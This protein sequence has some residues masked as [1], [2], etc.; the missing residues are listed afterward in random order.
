MKRKFD[1]KQKILK[2]I[3]LLAVLCMVQSTTSYAQNTVTINSKM[4]KITYQSSQNVYV[5]FE[6][7]DG[8]TAGDTLYVKEKNKL[9]PVVKI[10]FISSKSCA[11]EKISTIS[12]NDKNIIFAFYEMKE[13]SKPE[14]VAVV[15]DTT[16]GI[17]ADTN[18]VTKTA[19]AEQITSKTSRYYP[20]SYNGRLSV[21]SISSVSN[22]VGS[23]DLQRWRYSF[24]YNN[25]LSEKFSFSN[26]IVFAY[27]ANSWSDIKTNLN[28]NLKIYDFTLS[29]RLDD[30]TTFWMGRHI[31]PRVS[32][33]GAVDGLQADRKFGNIYMGFMIGSRPNF[34]DYSY[35]IKLFE[36]GGYTGIKSKMGDGYMD[37]TVAVF[38]QMNNMSTD[39]RYLYFQHTN[40]IIPMIR[41]F[42]SS[43]VDLFKKEKG[44]IKNTFDLTSLYLS[45]RFAPSNAF[46]LSAT[47]DTRKNVIYYETYKFLIDTLFQ[48]ETRQGFRL[49]ANFRPFNRMFLG[50]N[51]GYRYRQG[52]LKPSRNYGGYISYLGI[53]MLDISPSLSYTKIMSSYVDGSDFGFKLNKYVTDNIDMSIG[54]RKLQY[55][56]TSFGSKTIQDIVSADLSFLILR[57][58]NFTINYEGVFEK[59]NTFSRFFIDL[60]TRF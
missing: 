26:Y 21:Q 33:I 44:A 35:N 36:F 55:S 60:T 32:N 54:Y 49:N 20:S 3:L 17:R 52:D 12:L 2:V 51:A 48:N 30:K 38:Q 46:S 9:I 5:S 41:L 18:L 22:I 4:G 7:T 16:T 1:M 56:Y 23:T 47:Y 37:N 19:S 45:I 42:L 50:L 31:N 57:N 25:D 40:S 58:L 53:P 29:Y 15:K 8:L 11:G 34:N 13:K 6:N 10:K 27:N 24:N 28:N 39:R 59:S 14:N 43:E